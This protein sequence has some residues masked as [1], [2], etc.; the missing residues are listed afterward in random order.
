MATNPVTVSDL[1]ARWRPLS[2]QETTNA[3]ALLDDAWAQLIT[4][5]DNVPADLDSG[6]MDSGLVRSVIRAAVLRVLRNPDGNRTE[7]F[8]DY[9]EGRDPAVSTGQLYFTDTELA[10]MRGVRPTAVALGLANDTERD[11]YWWPW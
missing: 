6:A 5:A 11:N 8:Q 3:Q 2:D 9:S 7:S 10:L 4:V 1:E